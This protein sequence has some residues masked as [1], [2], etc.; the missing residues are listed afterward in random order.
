MWPLNAR[1]R[2]VYDDNGG[3]AG[4]LRLVVGHQQMIVVARLRT[5]LD[6]LTHKLER[7]PAMV[8]ATSDFD[9]RP[10][11]RATDAPGRRARRTLAVIRPIPDC[12]GGEIGVRTF[13]DRAIER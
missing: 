13:D 10:L 3:R 7:G 11:E 2:R 1:E 12:V 5:I 8:E 9:R 6:D 4:S